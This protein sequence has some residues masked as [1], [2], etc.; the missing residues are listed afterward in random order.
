[1]EINWIH[2]L[3]AGIALGA[4]LSSVYVLKMKPHNPIEN[5]AEAVIKKETGLDV[6]LSLTSSLKL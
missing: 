2:G 5:I 6:D 1:M 4:G 3:I